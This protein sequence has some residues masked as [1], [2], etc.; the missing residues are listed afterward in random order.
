MKQPIKYTTGL[1]VLLFIVCFTKVMAQGVTDT[2]INNNTIQII[3][4]YKPV[5]K[6]VSKIEFQPR[7]AIVDTN[8]RIGL[9]YK[10]PQQQLL[11]TYKSVP[12]NPLALGKELKGTALPNFVSLGIGNL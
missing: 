4:A 6:A 9:H 5:V 11:Y 3:Q 2:L 8:Y 12:I 7:Q 10:V 1:L